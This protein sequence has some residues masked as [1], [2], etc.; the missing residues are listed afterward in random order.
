MGE[1]RYEM[2]TMSKKR[3]LYCVKRYKGIPVA[4]YLMKNGSSALIL[5]SATI[6][7]FEPEVLSL[8]W[9]TQGVW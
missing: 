5:T 2:G 3:Y 6:Q 9:N 7:M 8:H 4:M 1:G